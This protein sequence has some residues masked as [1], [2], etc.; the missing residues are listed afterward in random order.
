MP[1]VFIVSREWSLRG[2][3]RGELREAG[4]AAMGME[5]V[6]DMARTIAGG[7]VPDVVVL[8]GVYLHDPPTQ[9][10]F[11]NLAPRLPLLII[12]SRLNPA[13]PV[14]GAQL[15]FRPVQVKEIVA[16][17]LAMLGTARS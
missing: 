3:V 17:V 16:R 13:P 5:A 2:A 10:S 9:Q 1:V 15:L 8:D 14:P 7:I 11:R 12:D 4:I 6:D